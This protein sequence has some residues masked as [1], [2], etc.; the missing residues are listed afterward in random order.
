MKAMA[1]SSKGSDFLLEGGFVCPAPKLY[2]ILDLQST[3]EINSVSW[4]KED[5]GLI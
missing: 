4:T 2:H 3:I 1:V 5:T